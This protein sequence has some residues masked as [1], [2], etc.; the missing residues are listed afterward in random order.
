[1]DEKTEA[2]RGQSTFPRSQNL[3]VKQPESKPMYFDFKITS[4]DS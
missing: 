2:Q 1:M 3:Y 4:S